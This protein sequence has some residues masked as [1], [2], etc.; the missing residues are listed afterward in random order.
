ML[1]AWTKL[2][3]QR[4]E[5][6]FEELP[7][8]KSLQRGKVLWRWCSHSKA[9]TAESITLWTTHSFIYYKYK[10]GRR[11]CTLILYKTKINKNWT[12]VLEITKP[13]WNNKKS[14]VQFLKHQFPLRPAATKTIHCSQG[15]K[16]NEAVVDFPASTRE[17]MD[18]VS[19]T[20]VRNSPALHILTLNKKIKV[21]E[22]T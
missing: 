13:F 11:K 2:T 6:E 12:P 21:N 20:R 15:D 3:R 9:K 19:L 1:F 10:A 17:H 22:Q 4:G 18:N 7:G 5:K 14:W 16:F 8:T